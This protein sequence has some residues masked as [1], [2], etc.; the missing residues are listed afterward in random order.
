MLIY[1]TVLFSVAIAYIYYRNNSKPYYI[2]VKHGQ[3]SP[4]P[5][6][7]NA[8]ST[9]TENSK[10]LVSPFL[11]YIDSFKTCDLIHQVLKEMNA[12]IEQKESNYIHATFT[13]PIMKFRDDVEIYLD[14]NLQLVHY[15]SQSR[16]G[17]YDFGVNRARYH[18]FTSLFDKKKLSDIN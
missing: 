7:P 5:D 17:Y 1:P 8:I 2:G 3:L 18:I 12:H 14:D 11:Y 6:F 9:Q 10:R 15:R 16:C 4:L 13:T